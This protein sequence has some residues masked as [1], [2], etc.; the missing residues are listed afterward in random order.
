MLATLDHCGRPNFPSAAVG[1]S[2]LSHV[3]QR[4]LEWVPVSQ[5]GSCPC[6][7]MHWLDSSFPVR[8]VASDGA[9]PGGLELVMPTCETQMVVTHGQQLR[10]PMYMHTPTSS[11]S[12]GD[13]LLK[14]PVKITGR[15]SHDNTKIQSLPPHQEVCHAA[16]SF[17]HWKTCGNG[18]SLKA[19]RDSGGGSK[20]KQ[21]SRAQ[22][23][24]SGGKNSPGPVGM[25]DGLQA[26]KAGNGTS[27][28]DSSLQRAKVELCVAYLPRSAMAG[29]LRKTFES[30]GPEGCVTKA[31]VT[32][33]KEG[34]SKCYGFVQ[35][36]HE[37]PA[38]MAL[39]ECQR[40]RV[41][42]HDAMGKAWHVKASWANNPGP[43]RH[44]RNA[45]AEE[46][47]LQAT[48][49]KQI[50]AADALGEAICLDTVSDLSTS[51]STAFSATAIAHDGV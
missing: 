31:W 20:R 13:D 1:Q 8:V 7:S 46:Q 51:A 30:F 37:G 23:Q 41:L 3:D 49:Y 6:P 5:A 28:A 25:A 15:V 2:A 47:T 27:K 16:D 39:Q 44:I 36:T 48:V 18:P 42:M 9:W 12:H 34:T 32:R 11:Q 38:E 29:D 45:K 26:A 50:G 21:R 4:S 17:P 10:R 33:T 35:F 22:A 43:L 40:G 14:N 24:G 19:A